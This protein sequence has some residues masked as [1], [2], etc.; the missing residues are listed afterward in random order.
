MRTLLFLLVL[1]LFSCKTLLLKQMMRTPVVE[2]VGSIEDFQ[3]RHGFSTRNSFILAGDTARAIEHLFLGL[4]E[5]YQ[6]YDSAGRQLCYR[7]SASCS[8]QEFRQLLRFGRDSFTVCEDGVLLH[9]LVA[10]TYNLRDAP[11]S[12]DEVD[13]AQYYL[14]V[15]WQ[16]FLGSRKGY[17]DRVQWMEEEIEQSSQKHKVTLI[18][19]N[20][21]LQARWGLRQGGRARLRFEKKDSLLSILVDRLPIRRSAP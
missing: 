13:K 11:G 8:G 20:T 18:K 5:G 21:D 15:Y 4:N 1:G 19:I 3:L 6:V 2:T 14:V 7:G 17:V 12:M 9:D 16:K 10:N